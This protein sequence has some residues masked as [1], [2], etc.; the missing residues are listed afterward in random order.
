M[1]VTVSRRAHFN[2]AHR[3]YR[4][5]WS[6]EKNPKDYLLRHHNHL[7]LCKW[8]PNHHLERHIRATLAFSATQNN[9]KIGLILF[10]RR[11]HSK[12]VCK[13]I[14]PFEL[15]AIINR[16]SVYHLIMYDNFSTFEVLIFKR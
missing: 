4:P 6:D 14:Y 3:L 16:L 11:Y 2:A 12:N 1:K 7:I 8:H 5:N 15:E 10:S 13:P 9:D